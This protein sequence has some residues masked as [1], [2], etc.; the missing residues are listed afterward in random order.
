[1]SLLK[2]LKDWLDTRPKCPDCGAFMI[3]D[4]VHSTHDKWYY[5]CPNCSKEVCGSK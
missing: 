5:L 3:Y 1:M 2:R 4:K